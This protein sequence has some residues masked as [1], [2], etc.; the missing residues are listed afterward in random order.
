MRTADFDYHLP[1]QTDR[2]DARPAAGRLP[3]ARL[4]ARGRRGGTLRRFTDI[5][6]YLRPGD[7][8]VANESRVLPARLFGHKVATTGRVE[9]L[10][11]RPAGD[12]PPG[13]ADGDLVWEALAKPGRSIR[14]ARG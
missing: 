7:L 10:L 3:S 13:A 11:L 9:A 1:A 4:A 14:R 12:R 6:S 5:L 8:L 2:A